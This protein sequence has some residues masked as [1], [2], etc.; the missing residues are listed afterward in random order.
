MT[1]YSGYRTI[2]R[3]GD[4]TVLPQHGRPANIASTRITS[5]NVS[6][7]KFSILLAFRLDNTGTAPVTCDVCVFADTYVRSNNSHPIGALPGNY[8]LFWGGILEDGSY[9]SLSII[10]KGY[11]L[12]RKSVV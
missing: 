11:P 2:L 6:L 5:V 3:V 12:D 4:V 1:T 8:G 9:L 10:G 7:S